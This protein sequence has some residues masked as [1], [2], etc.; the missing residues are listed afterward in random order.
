VRGI[1][2]LDESPLL[3]VK[4]YVRCFDAID[5]ANDGWITGLEFRGKPAGR[6]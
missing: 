6:E 1:D 4:P 3:D 5:S 2:V